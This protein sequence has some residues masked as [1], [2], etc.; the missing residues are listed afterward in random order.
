MSAPRSP[1]LPRWIARAGG[2]VIVLIAVFGSSISAAG[3]AKVNP[4]PLTVSVA[5]GDSQVVTITLDEPI[6]APGPDPAVVTLAF[7]VDDP[8]RVSLSTSSLVW[9]ASEWAQPRQLTVSATLDGVYNASG[10]VTLD[11]VVSSNSEYYDGFTTSITVSIADADP[12]P[13]T[14]T[15]TTG[16]PPTQ[17]PTT[18]AVTPAEVERTTVDP[19]AV[20]PR[21]SGELAETGV[22]VDVMVVAAALLLAMGAALLVARRPSGHQEP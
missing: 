8:S 3:A 15:V 7:T 9:A 17:A 22:D 1:R 5:E 19:V 20:S 16:A 10:T 13:T 18:A 14:T 2:G 12:A 11:G 6:I 21:T 4:S